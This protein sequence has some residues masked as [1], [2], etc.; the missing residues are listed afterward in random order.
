VNYVKKTLNLSITSKDTLIV[1]DMQN[2]FLPGGALAVKDADQII[3]VINDYI[4]IFIEAGAKVI[5]SRDWHPKNHVSFTGQGG[6][7]PAHCVQET[8]GAKFSSRLKMPNI[9]TI[10]SKATDPHIEAYS[11]FDG[12]G[13]DER[14]KA[15]G[16][17]RLFIGGLATDYCVVNSVM[18]ARK[19]GFEVAVLSDAT[20]GIDVQPGDTDKALETMS[21]VG[22]TQMSVA[23]FPEP[24]PLTGEVA[25]AQ[26]ADDKPLDESFVK[27]KARM[28]ARGSYR[29][30]RRERA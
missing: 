10:V 6:T 26:V 13:L 2:D 21:R 28:R 19:L 3:P 25:P 12:T 29:Q 14:L 18:D 20:C 30:I 11:I 5:A 24:E 4:R 15:E 16:V 17:T 7:W 9:Y 27:K 23:D 1:T 22:A 8:D